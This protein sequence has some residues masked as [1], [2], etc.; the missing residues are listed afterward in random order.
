LLA[1]NTGNSV[2]LIVMYNLQVNDKKLYDITI[3]DKTI[4]INGNSVHFDTINIGG[5]FYH[6]VYNGKSYRIIIEDSSLDKKKLTLNINGSRI[7]ID[8]K[9]FLD[10]AK[11]KIGIREQ[12]SQSGMPV[13]S[14]MPGKISKIFVSEGEYIEE[15]APLLILNAMKMENILKSSHTGLVKQVL[16]QSGQNVEKGQI[17]I[18]F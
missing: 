5:D 15:G 10:I 1:G 17:L 12:S 7:Q 16:V 2:K 8:L 18:Q 13:K 3:S 9:D 6:I 14:P 11:D 4:R